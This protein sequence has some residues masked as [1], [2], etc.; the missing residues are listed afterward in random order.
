MGQLYDNSI[1]MSTP[2]K[3]CKTYKNIQIISDNDDVESPIEED[4]FDENR[5]NDS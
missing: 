3:T 5:I 4:E 2:R 1:F